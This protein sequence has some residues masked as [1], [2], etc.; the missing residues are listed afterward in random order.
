[1][2]PG[3]QHQL[4]TQTGP[5]TP[6]GELFRRYWMPALLSSELEQPDGPPVRLTLLSE[7]LIA[8]R[9]SQGRLGLIDGF[10]AHRGVSLWFARNEHSGLRCPYHGWKFDYTGQCL[11]IPSEPA[12]SLHHRKIKLAS[13]PLIERGGVLWTY[14]GPPAQQPPLPEFEF[15][16]VPATRRYIG[17]RLQENNYLQAMEG[18]IDPHHVGFLHSGELA[19]DPL[20]GSNAA[21]RYVRPD[22]AIKLDVR[23]SDGGLA[24]AYGR[25]AQDSQVYWRVMQWVMPNFTLIPPFAQHAV[26]GHFWVP[27]DD[28]T[29]WVW[30]FDYHP[31]RDLSAAELQAAKDGKGMHA[32]LIPGTFR[33]AAN[34]DND[35]LMD[36]DAQRSGR[37][38]SGVEG[39]AMQDASLQE[40]MGRVQD[41]SREHLVSSDRV[42]VMARRRLLEATLALRGA[43]EPAGTGVAAQRV[44][45]ATTMLPAGTP[46][47]DA[48]AD[49]LI[50]REGVDFLTE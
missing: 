39:V 38:F 48:V 31:R 34:R 15:A 16:M 13:Y 25:A 32:R 7:Q 43:Q 1:M 30:T 12:N 47:H 26:H 40:S 4:L 49:S 20:I 14:M 17:K 3:Q 46:V 23:R 2:E 41:R 44:R 8:F 21:A 19:H 24:I 11:E 42:I 35:Y 9:D 37:Y 10:C 50:A 36:R 18:G 6:M 28:G 29:C 33:T 22:L 45:S 5:G 27:V